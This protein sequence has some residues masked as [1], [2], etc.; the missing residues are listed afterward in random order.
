[1]G[2]AHPD[3]EGT[4]L[5]L[6]ERMCERGPEIDFEVDVPIHKDLHH[7][8]LIRGPRL[9]FLDVDEMRLGDPSF[10]LAHFCTYLN[11]LATRANGSGALAEALERA[12]L[13]E[14]ERQTGWRSDERFIYFC[15]Y[16]CLKI[17]K[18][19]CMIEGVAP[20]PTGAEQRRQVAAVLEHG[21]DLV[22]TLR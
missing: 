21:R 15:A 4:A 9:A 3:Q 12:F 6:L 19:L 11:L 20:L 2:A 22:G 16:T 10:D 18:Q 17:A 13:E 1:V 14:Y 7:E 8:H 5:E